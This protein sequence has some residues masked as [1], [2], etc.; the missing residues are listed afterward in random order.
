MSTDFKTKFR[1]SICFW[2]LNPKVSIY[3][4]FL[5]GHFSVDNFR[6]K[7]TN[8]SSFRNLDVSIMFV[9]RSGRRLTRCP[10]KKKKTIIFSVAVM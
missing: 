1:R 6:I 8:Q 7:N 9:D 10:Q 4:D 2:P 5:F 3:L